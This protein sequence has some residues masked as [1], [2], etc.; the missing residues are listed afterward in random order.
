MKI[1]PL[2][3]RQAIRLRFTV[4][5][6]R[7][8][9]APLSG[10]K[11]ENK[12]HRQI[13]E[14]IGQKIELD[15]LAGNFDPT[16]ERYRHRSAGTEIVVQSTVRSG[17]LEL[18]DAYVDSRN[19]KPA[20]KADHYE[21][22]RRMIV[23]AGSPSVGSID[24]FVRYPCSSTTFNRRLGM[25]RSAIAWGIKKKLITIDPLEKVTTRE[26]TLEEVEE[27][28]SKK[29]PF[30]DE[31]ISKILKYF[32]EYHPT[33]VPFVAFQLYSGVR[34]GEA[35]GIAWKHID[36]EKK[37]IR[38]RQAIVRERGKYK[39]IKKKPK[40]LQSDRIL[41]MSDRIYSLLLSMKPEPFNPNDLIFKTVKGCII[42]HGNFRADYWEP[43]LQKLKI[44]YRKPYATR[45]TLLSKG[46]ESGLTIPQVSQ[47]A[48]HK[49]G[50]MILQHYGR[51]INS[52]KLPE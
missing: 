11:W 48:G 31:E 8:N 18:W 33:Y 26:E 4:E 15:I 51:V 32:I 16:L 21:M 24:W 45:H 34:T 13:V 3:N 29:Q 37:E 2:K 14:A 38:I 41:K 23:K 35:V 40:T 1:S 17:W 43:A 39:K 52:Q 42:D 5:G 49:D 19:L 10:G 30:T 47:I 6:Q 46:L 50:R 36:F 44:Q 20:T 27:R 28:E 7:F 9:F 22:V 25:L 12:R